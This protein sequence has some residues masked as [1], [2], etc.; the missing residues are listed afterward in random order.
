MKRNKLII[1]LSMQNVISVCKEIE[2]IYKSL[3]Y[4]TKN[5]INLYVLLCTVWIYPFVCST[6]QIV[7]FP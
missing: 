1:I 6:S 2:E 7:L 3:Y 4:S 5:K